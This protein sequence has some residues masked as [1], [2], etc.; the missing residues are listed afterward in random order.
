MVKNLKVK[1]FIEHKKRVHIK[2]V[3]SCW[4]FSAGKCEFGDESCW[5]S[6]SKNLDNFKCNICGHV[7]KTKNESHYHQKRMHVSSIPQCKNASQKACSYGADKCWFQHNETEDQE[8]YENQNQN[9]EITE[10]LFNMMEK[11][12]ERIMKIEKQMEMTS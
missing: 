6:H 9:Q 11:F 1:G 12:T 2:N 8:K 4:N 5:F 7:F 3:A 10:K